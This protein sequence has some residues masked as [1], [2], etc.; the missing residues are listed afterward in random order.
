MLSFDEPE[1]WPAAGE[2]AM[3]GLGGHIE[4]AKA[5]MDL[6]IRTYQL[7][8]KDLHNPTLASDF[9]SSASIRANHCA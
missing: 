1:E 6:Q 3:A 8:G 4:L 9:M 7:I 2:L 5:R